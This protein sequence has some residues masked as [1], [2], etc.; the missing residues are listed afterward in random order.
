[1]SEERNTRSKAKAADD[2]GASQGR[3][4]GRNTTFKSHAYKSE[5]DPIEPS[6]LVDP[7]STGAHLD[8]PQGFYQATA[9]LDKG[10]LLGELA[11]LAEVPDTRAAVETDQS[12]PRGLRLIIVAGPEIGTEW[13]FKQP[14]VVMGR[15]E[16]CEIVM[17]DIAVSRR[18]ARISLEGSHFVLTDLSSGNGTFLNGVRIEKE[19]LA[20]GDEIVIGERTLRFVELN[21]APPT[22]AAHPIPQSFG[23]EP[24]VGSVPRVSAVK[25]PA[26]KASQVRVDAVPVEE[27]PIEK[28]SLKAP[29]AK[30]QTAQGAALRRVVL[31]AV[32]GVVVLAALGAGFWYYRRAAAEKEAAALIERAKTEFLQGIELVKARR[33]GDAM[34]LFER[35]LAVRADYAPAQEYRVHCEKELAV[36]KALE[37]AR[38]LALSQKY[39]E[40]L[41]ML[42]A[43]KDETA[44]REEIE[45]AKK[46]YARAISE[47]Y[48]RD[49]RSKLEAG[50]FDGAMDLAMSALGQTPSLEAAQALRDEIEDAKR[51]QNA[52][53]KKKEEVPPELLRA[54]ALYKNEQI[55]AAIDAAEAAGGPNASTYVARMKRMKQL[56]ADAEV[57]HKKKAAA[58]LLR[59]APAALEIDQQI[60]GQ[61][62]KVRGKLKRFYADG[63]YLK[64]IEAY[65][66][67]D[68]VRAYQL[69]SDALK[70][71]PGHALSESR[72]AEL[73]RK[74]RDLYYEGY[75]MKDS[76]AAETRK[77]FKR[78]TQMTRPDN[79]Y[80]KLASKWLAANGG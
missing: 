36:W 13:G 33:F 55:G 12:A 63:L 25:E 56:L 76:N 32:A 62:G 19:L 43:L 72:L 42:E 60:G 39:F 38:L 53:V 59:I 18:H 31:L 80:H 27:G 48:L 20:S 74:A 52:P 67:K 68:F 23:D 5:L 11:D 17:N 65:A 6:D 64:G 21:E 1:M 10:E 61:D 37:S 35:V 34:W 71:Q 73:S 2:R 24:E 8:A 45:R 40:A 9:M 16:E 46:T 79:Q 4:P 57:A 22:A 14:E 77:I 75:V 69:L 54:V 50:D 30:K 44:Y 15:D 28:G 78:L 51:A 47:L 49:A 58:E 66:E 41:A 70:Q 7:D 3:R 29:V 26:M